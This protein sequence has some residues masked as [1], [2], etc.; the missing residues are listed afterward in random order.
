MYVR[1][2]EHNKCKPYHKVRKNE[3]LS[4]DIRILY[5]LMSTLIIKMCLFEM[6]IIQLP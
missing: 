4:L 1:E 5:V 3:Q 2:T 6:F